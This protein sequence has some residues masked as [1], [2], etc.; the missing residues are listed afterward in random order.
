MFLIL[1][2]ITVSIYPSLVSFF[3]ILALI[4]SEGFKIFKITLRDNG[5][6]HFVPAR[7]TAITTI[8]VNLNFI[9]FAFIA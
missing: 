5:I 6:C 8:I 2:S 3:T 1:V 7:Y 9:L 4:L